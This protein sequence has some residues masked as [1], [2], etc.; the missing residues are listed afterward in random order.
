MAATV[1]TRCISRVY[2]FGANMAQTAVCQLVPKW[3]TLRRNETRETVTQRK[4]RIVRQTLVDE[5]SAVESIE[6]LQD[7]GQPKAGFRHTLVRD[8][9]S[10]L[11]VGREQ[12]NLL[13]GMSGLASPA[14]T[15]A[16]I[17]LLQTTFFVNF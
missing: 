10:L 4:Y 1:A 8:L 14:A 5:C 7:V 2:G 15:V 9:L 6:L 13:R 12:G 16:R 11:L 17:S 3:P